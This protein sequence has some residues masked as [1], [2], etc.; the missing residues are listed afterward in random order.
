MSN[1]KSKLV[2]GILGTIGSG[3]GTA[4]RFLKKKYGFRIISMGNLIRAL[5]RKLKISASRKNLQDLQ[6]RYRKRYGGDYFISI[7]WQKIDSSMHKRWI[8]DGIRHN[9]DASASRKNGAVLIFIDAKPEIR[10]ERMKK[11]RR[12]GFSRTIEQFKKEE[13]REWKR[14]NFKKTITYAH[15]RMDNSKGQK[16]LFSQIDRLMRKII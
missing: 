2:I 15:Y 6:A 5:A 1:K 8:I 12:K 16:L 11:R 14:F 4:A 9:A 3:K 7:A 10:F 13:Q